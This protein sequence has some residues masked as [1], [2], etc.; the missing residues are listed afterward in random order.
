LAPR[1]IQSIGASV[2]APGTG[3]G[4]GSVS[5][6]II[7]P[8]GR[9][10]TVRKASM[11]QTRRTGAA[12]GDASAAGGSVPLPSRPNTAGS[13]SMPPGLSLALSMS[14]GAPVP[15]GAAGGSASKAVANPYSSLSEADA[16]REAEKQR[17]EK[18]RRRRDAARH[19]RE[20]LFRRVCS[21]LLH[22]PPALAVRLPPRLTFPELLLDWCYRDVSS[23]EHERLQQWIQQPPSR[24]I[25]AS[26]HHIFDR[27]DAGQGEAGPAGS[28]AA[29]AAAAAAVV[30]A[31]GASPTTGAFR[32]KVVLGEVLHA[33]KQSVHKPLVDGLLQYRGHNTAGGGAGGLQARVDFPTLIGLLFNRSHTER[34]QKKI[35]RWARPSKLLTAQHQ[36]ELRALFHSFVADTLRGPGGTA[37]HHHRGHTPSAWVSSGPSA[38]AAA[39]VAA[40]NA[41][42][43]DGAAHAKGVCVCFPLARADLASSLLAAPHRRSWSGAM[44]CRATT[45]GS[46]F[47]SGVCVR[48]SS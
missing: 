20:L 12:G 9:I 42:P 23:H 45:C 1:V 46:C 31:A 8:S 47:A 30:G 18:D 6:R 21:V 48:L 29:A 33:L 34:L 26:M 25:I 22:L 14:P 16:E 27:V 10:R 44:A 43:G 7:G 35:A 41:A 37:G 13:P 3:F 39:V 11:R 15:I 4:S 28:S 2:T 5:G 32:G 24:A 17:A 38:A 19:E 40:A 36:S